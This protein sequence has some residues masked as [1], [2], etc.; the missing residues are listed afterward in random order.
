M[1]KYTM[2]RSLRLMGVVVGVMGLA[3]AA[4]APGMSAEMKDFGGIELTIAT[5]PS[6]WEIR[7][8]EEIGPAMEKMGVKLKFIGG[9]SEEF[10]AKMIAA[11]GTPSFD[12]VE[13]TD[14]VFPDMR[15][16]DFLAKMNLNNIPNKKF[17]NSA[18]YND[19][20]VGYWNTHAAIIWNWKKFDE[21]GIP[22][23]TELEDLL[24][25]KLK[26]KVIF[27]TLTSY[28][29]VP[30]ILHLAK[31]YGGDEKN[32]D[33]ALP[34][35]R[36]FADQVHS[37][38]DFTPTSQ[39]MK[40]GDAWAT[41]FAGNSAIRLLDAGVPMGV[42][43]LVI[44]GHEGVPSFGYLGV[45]KGSKNQ[46][47]AEAFI[48]EAID[49]E[50]QEGMLLN[51]GTVTVNSLVQARY[52]DEQRMDKFGTFFN[53]MTKEKVED[54][55]YMKFEQMDRREWGKKLQRVQVGK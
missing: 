3:V 51:N 38:A 5:F 23:P 27:P 30:Y 4:A 26:G 20:K 11:K 21:M 46:E 42:R 19:Y 16:G 12:V 28:S 39:A 13:I 48:N 44:D 43:H 14:H 6:T 53:L 37:F 49:W 50:F 55:Y 40:N 36:K 9:R 15:K 24:H 7:F 32:I 25:P 17:L 18:L 34:V 33:P 22:A 52:A 45:V 8:R 41:L 31:K 10:L 54:F 29:A 47:A 2:K 1:W 35:L